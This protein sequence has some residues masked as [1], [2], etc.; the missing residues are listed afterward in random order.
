MAE[1]L[2]RSEIDELIIV[3]FFSSVKTVNVKT[4]RQISYKF[5]RFS[6]GTLGHSSAFP[7]EEVSL[8]TA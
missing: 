7:P 4:E 1:A 6:Q 3:P 2:A 5:C 8:D